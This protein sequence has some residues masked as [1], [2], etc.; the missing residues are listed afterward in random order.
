MNE[1]LASTLTVEEVES[2][3]INFNILVEYEEGEVFIPEYLKES[4]TMS[5]SLKRQEWRSWHPYLPSFYLHVQEKFYSWLQGS[6]YLWKHNR[7]GHYRTFYGVTYPFIVE[8][9]DNPASLSTK[10][11]DYL[12]F[13]TEVK[14]FDSITQ[15]YNDIRD[16]TFNKALF[17][18]T[19]QT[20]GILNIIFKQNLAQN[21][22]LQQTQ[23]TT[24]IGNIIADRNERDWTLND[25]RDIRMTTA[26]PMFIKD[27]AQLQGNYYIDKIVNPAAISY[28]KSWNEL[29]SFRD[30][31][32]V[33]RLIFDTF[34]TS[35]RLTFY[36][37]YL[38][39]NMS[40][41]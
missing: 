29:E 24:S 11:W 23:N 1:I 28:T 19:E 35:K 5:Y 37:S 14:E 27:V 34:D 32:L 10:V 33:I 16:L 25:M 26:V 7:Q 31:F 40:E 12:M 22:L 39:K 13:Q 8:Y 41:R 4:W 18:N 15:E 2:Q 20:S 9:V 36:Y 30:K 38:Q 17:Y 3:I 21:Y 6:Q